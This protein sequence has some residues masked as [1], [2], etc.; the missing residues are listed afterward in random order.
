M[1]TYARHLQAGR[2]PYT[3]VSNNN[4]ELPQQPPDPAA[5]L[6]KIADATDVGDALDEFSPPQEA[7]K[8]LKAKLAEL[9]G[10]TGEE[11]KIVRIPEG[12]MLRPGM[13]DA[14][15]PLLRKR[16][17]VAGD[18]SNLRYDGTLVDAVKKYQ[19]GADLNADGMLGATTV[20]ALNG[21]PHRSAATDRHS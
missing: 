5:V 10:T 4:I 13:E 7:Y 6:T 18:D 17:N 16:L 12:A 19:K 2:F 11:D 1:L 14:R 9:R 21:R 8:K 15:V 3:R 20:R